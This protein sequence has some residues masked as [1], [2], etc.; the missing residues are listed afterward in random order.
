MIASP[1]HDPRSLI[2]DPQAM[3]HSQHTITSTVPVDPQAT[4]HNQ[5]TVL[6]VDFFIFVVDF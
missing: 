4:M 3:I 5:S 1:I 2:N 6:V